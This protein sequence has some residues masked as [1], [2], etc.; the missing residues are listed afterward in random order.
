MSYVTQRSVNLQALIDSEI[1]DLQQ[2]LEHRKTALQAQVRD[3]CKEKTHTL[4]GQKKYLETMRRQAS[5]Y[6]HFVEE[7]LRKG[8]HDT[9]LSV[10]KIVQG[11][12][13]GDVEESISSPL[14]LSPLET[15]NTFFAIDKTTSRALCFVGHVVS[16]SICV[17]ACY[18]EGI[19]LS[20]ATVYD[21]A[22]FTVTLLGSD[23]NPCNDRL[24]HISVELIA[25]ANTDLVVAGK[26]VT[27][28][29]NE[30]EA[31]YVPFYYGDCKLHI[32]IAGEV[33]K[34]SPFSVRVLPTCQFRGNFVRCISIG[35]IRPWGLAIAKNGDLVVIDNEGL[36]GVHIFTPDGELRMEPF[37]DTVHVWNNHSPDGTC[38]WP[39]GVALDDDDNIFVVDGDD[40]RIV[41]FDADRKYRAT[42]G[43]LG[44][45]L[46][47]F[48]KPIGIAIHRTQN[49]LY[50]CDRGNSRIQVLQPN[51]QNGTFSSVTG[52]GRFWSE[53]AK[54]L[55]RPWDIAFDSRDNAYIVDCD[56]YCLRVVS[57]DGELLQSI[58]RRGEGRGEFLHI[59]SVCVDRSDFIYTT[60]W[61]RCLVTVF[62]PLGE[63]V[64]EFGSKGEKKGSGER[65]FYEPKGIAVDGKGYVYIS[66]G[67]C[68][69][70]FE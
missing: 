65:Q 61:V 38:Y 45:K 27:Q 3:I 32:K 20:R 68:V 53:T 63:F 33:I 11:K 60:D 5:D 14:E 6:L 51:M 67:N 39:R 17:A 2:L 22:S 42:V 8:S 13:N 31:S 19:G 1:G 41:C 48:N 43:E 57:P 29:G 66:T 30:I 15:A 18:A 34:D 35:L 46:M 54:L 69:K 25:D 21:E 64:M 12:P 49:D 24:S 37:C 36:K 26:L 56:N 55:R 10:S 7:S 16:S 50:I 59:S 4:S 62:N 58:G 23:G 9:I 44:N 47:E 52:F 40:N 28:C 70:V